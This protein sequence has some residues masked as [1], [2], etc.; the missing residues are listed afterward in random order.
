MWTVQAL[1]L[2]NHDDKVTYIIVHL[3]HLANCED[4]SVSVT[5][6]GEAQLLLHKRLANI[7]RSIWSMNARIEHITPGPDIDHCYLEQYEDQ[8]SGF[9][10]GIVPCFA[11]YCGNEGLSRLT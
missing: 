8:M 7:E 5:L 4:T 6:E 1:F 3:D 9:E 11:K 10:I 2:D